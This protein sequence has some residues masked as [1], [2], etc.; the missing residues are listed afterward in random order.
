MS[1]I[2]V[3]RL[4]IC[5]VNNTQED[6]AFEREDPAPYEGGY[7]FRQIR[8]LVAAASS[9]GRILSHSPHL[10][11]HKR[12]IQLYGRMQLKGRMQLGL[13]FLLHHTLEVVLFL[14]APVF[15]KKDF[16]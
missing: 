2:V 5:F 16:H 1:R 9:P 3:S 14:E 4:I 15:P 6:A 13:L 12:R 7:S 11:P 10:H 8:Y